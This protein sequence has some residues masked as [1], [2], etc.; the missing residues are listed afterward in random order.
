MID[1]EALFR[2]G[3]CRLLADAPEISVVGDTGGMT[4]ALSLVTGC[5]PHVVLLGIR[6]AD[7]VAT[8][9]RRLRQAAP[10][11]A[12]VVLG[13]H[14]PFGLV[15]ELLGVG[16]RGYLLRTAS[17]QEVIATVRACRDSHSRV[18]LSVPPEALI[19]T[20]GQSSGVRLT[21]R[22]REVLDLTACA[23]SNAQIAASLGLS[24]PTV[25]RHLRN[26][27]GK[28]GAVSRIDAVN[29]ARAASLISVR[30]PAEFF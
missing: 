26:I 7:G 18:F 6:D 17:G 12:V 15:Q 27:F 2:E 28:L 29:K 1:G 20:T 4:E 11:A 22:E 14:A 21:E 10:Q 13:A 8:A 24:E 19:D 5:S 16:V 3:L 25:K 30:R 9:V 23:M